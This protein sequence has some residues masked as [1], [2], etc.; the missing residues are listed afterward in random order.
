MSGL[1]YPK[2]WALISG[3]KDSLSM[4]QTL[5]EAGKLE[6]CVS[7]KTGVATPD[8]AQFVESVCKNRRWPLEFYETP[9]SYDDLVIE[10]GFPGPGRHKKFMDRLKGRCVRVFKSNHPR[11]VLASGT[12]SD[13]SSRRKFGTMPLG[14]WEGVPVIAPIYDWTTDETWEFFRDRGFERA[15][16]YST[17]QI[18]GDC[19]CGAF[20]REGENEALKFHYPEVG[21]RF[22][23]LTAQLKEK[24]PQRCEWGWGWEQPIK[25]RT[26]GES[27]ICSECAPRDL[28]PETIVAK[29]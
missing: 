3:G 14:V 8:W 15:P 23:V 6:G 26:L 18:S 29:P 4:A 1:Y 20:A 13:E 19:L 2:C 7:F 10:H 22:D 24:C 9:E 11:G 21:A 5:H 16:A 25:R 17:L 27:L 28:S 12:R